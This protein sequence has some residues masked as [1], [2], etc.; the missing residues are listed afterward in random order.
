MS[1]SL[2]IK[3][4]GA[5]E[6]NLQ[7]IRLSLYPGELTVITGLSGTG[8]STLL[9]D[10]LHAEGQRRYVETFSPYVRQYMESLPRPQVESI[11][12]ARPSI[13]VEQKNSIRNS[14]STVGTMTELCDYFKVW[15]SHV[16]ELHDPDDQGKIIK[17]ES[18]RSQASALIKNFS[19]QNIVIGF[20]MARGNLIPDD[21]LSFL[22]QAGHTRILDNGR[23]VRIENLIGSNWKQSSAF[24]AVENIK[25]SQTNQSRITEA[26]TLCLKLG[27]GAAEA[28]N[29]RGKL[30][31]GLHEY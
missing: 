19:Q 2:P 30:L 23:Y 26:I 22:I 24:V 12:N 18:P 13:A 15:F 31:S 4:V 20:S 9:F 1:N 28:R 6:N 5:T 21:F 10:V 25:V 27:K 14:R 7:N 29:V 11:S 3:L 16:C 8:K 17:H